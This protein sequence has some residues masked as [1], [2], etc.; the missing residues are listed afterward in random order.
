[1]AIEQKTRHHEK[2]LPPNGTINIL[3]GGEDFHFT[4]VIGETFSSPSY[5]FCYMNMKIC[6]NMNGTV[7]S[8]S[9]HH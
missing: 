7:I 4:R 2:S 1:M 6:Y 9:N 8:S 5:S 3:F